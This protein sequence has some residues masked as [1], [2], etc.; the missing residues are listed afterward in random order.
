MYPIRLKCHNF[1]PHK[2]AE[3]RMTYACVASDNLSKGQYDNVG[4]QT[5]FS[6]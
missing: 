4:S 1:I 5:S 3:R 2:I 6:S